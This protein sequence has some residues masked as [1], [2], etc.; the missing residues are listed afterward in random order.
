MRLLHVLSISMF[1]LIALYLAIALLKIGTAI[2][3]VTTDYARST[4]RS[5]M[6][7]LTLAFSMTTFLR[8]SAA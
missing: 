6:M 4:R 5:G 3:I 1:A 2:A 7:M 8:A